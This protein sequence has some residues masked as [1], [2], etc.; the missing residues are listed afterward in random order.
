MS[1]HKL[2]SDNNNNLVKQQRPT[3]KHQFFKHKLGVA[4]GAA[5][6]S[7]M[8]GLSI[9]A[10]R[11]ANEYVANSASSQL[12][13]LSLGL[14]QLP[15]LATKNITEMGRVEKLTDFPL[16]KQ[17]QGKTITDV[18]LQGDRK[19]IALTFDDGPSEKFT[20]NILYI[21]DYHNIKATFFLL[22]RNVREYPQKTKQIHLKGHALANHSWSHPYAMQSPAGAAA[23]IENTSAW[24]EKTTGVKSKL[25][26]PPGGYLHNGMASYAA[27][28]GQTVVMWSADSKDYYESSQGITRRILS[29]ASPGGI[30]LLHDGGGDR[31]K[32]VSALPQIIAKLKEQGYEFVTVPELLELK[33]QETI[34]AGG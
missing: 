23:Q 31:T 26:R 19:V 12:D 5:T 27:K 13:G 14:G 28:Q 8:A 11:A 29:E 15:S 20:N 33:E 32:T 6:L 3:L 25:F 17:F 9:P 24:I 34:Q 1:T 2:N 18:K 16:P 4:L 30:I 22:G 7:F 21:L 10:G